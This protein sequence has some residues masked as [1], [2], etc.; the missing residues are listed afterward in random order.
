MFSFPPNLSPLSTDSNKDPLLK[1]QPS[2]KN[3][4]T[5]NN[6]LAKENANVQFKDSF[7]LFNS[8]LNKAYQRMADNSA[9][10]PAA[11]NSKMLPPAYAETTESVEKI[12]SKQAAGNIL[13]FISAKLKSDA[14]DGADQEAL[15]QRLEQGLEGFNRGFNE[16][17][18]QIESMG[19]LTPKLGE[20]INDAY[21]RVTSGIEQLREQILG[22][23]E[24]AEQVS[25]TG[26]QVEHSQASSFSLE[27]ITQ[28]GDR[29]SIEIARSSQSSFTALEQQNGESLQLAASGQSARTASFELQVSGELDQGELEAINN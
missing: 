21:E 17:R 2:L 29:V 5:P 12:T 10:F 18:E 3:Q 23:A 22:K 11:A 25:R 9:N 20:E 15:L 14:A 4:S 28:D 8:L 13:G 16:A 7:E 27:L 24:T 1:F 6:A 26:L 19:L